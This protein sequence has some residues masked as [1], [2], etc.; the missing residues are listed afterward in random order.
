[1][2][3][4]HFACIVYLSVS[5]FFQDSTFGEVAKISIGRTFPRGKGWGEGKQ[6]T[7]KN[8]VERW[9]KKMIKAQLI[10]SELKEYA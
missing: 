9:W 2:K 8:C 7:G 5:T 3:T 10:C 1:M 4:F 6:Q